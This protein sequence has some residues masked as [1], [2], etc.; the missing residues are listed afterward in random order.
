[1]GLGFVVARFGL[2][3]RTLAGRF[4]GPPV[5]SSGPPFWLG[6]VFLLLGVAVC[7]VS[8]V[9]HARLVSSLRRGGDLVRSPSRLA[10]LV[11]AALAAAGLAMA[12]YLFSVRQ[13]PKEEPMSSDLKTG[14]VTLESKHSVDQ[15]VQKLETILAAK[16]VKLF[17]LVDHGGEAEQAGLH[18]PATKL[19]IFGSPKAGTPV[20]LAAP[21]AA[22]D[23]P[24]KILVREDGSGNTLISFNA[25]EYL[26]ARHSIPPELIANLSVVAALAAAAAD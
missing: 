26:Q 1:M 8:S 2:F 22:I 21:S 4:S 7:I 14:M 18:M 19:L 20:M 17:A 6:T 9:N 13:N 12:I 25:P 24:L 15:T 3:L 5:T 11:A 23:L 10:L 16:G